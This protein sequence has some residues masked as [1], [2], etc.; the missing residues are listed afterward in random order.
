MMDRTRHR[1]QTKQIDSR[2]HRYPLVPQNPSVLLFLIPKPS[3]KPGWNPKQVLTN[4][5]EADDF[6]VLESLKQMGV[7]PANFTR[8]D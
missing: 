2:I 8:S 4:L 1:L 7:F 5:P 3:S 6:F